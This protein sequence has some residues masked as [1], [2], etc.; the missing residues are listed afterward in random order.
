L[1]KVPEPV[2]RAPSERS[3]GR[4][5]VRRIGNAINLGGHV[6]SGPEHRLALIRSYYESYVND[7]RGL[8]E[9]VLHPQFTFSSPNDDDNIDLETYFG[10]CWPNHAV[11][12]Q[13]ELLN[14]YAD[15]DHALVR[16]HALTHDGSEFGNVE[17][18][19][20]RDDLISHID[21]HFG[22]AMAGQTTT[23]WGGEAA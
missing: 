6:Q 11:M 1:A 22:P 17:Y 12:K 20:F 19:V 13:F 5:S 15:V 2:S 18:F 21:C 16:Y 7:D 4:V 9:S 10:R 8:N 23:N 3:F 14:V